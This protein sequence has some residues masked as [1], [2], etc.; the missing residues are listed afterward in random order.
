LLTE[1]KVVGYLLW[2]LNNWECFLTPDFGY[3]NQ[4]HNYATLVRGIDQRV[5]G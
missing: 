4:Q 2:G 5:K 3:N 1:A